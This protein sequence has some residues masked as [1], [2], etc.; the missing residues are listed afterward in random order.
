MNK[1]CL[2]GRLTTKPELRT[3]SNNL[4]T[5]RFTLAV[6]RNFANAQGEREADFITI[7]AWRKQAENICQYL[8]KGSLVSV[9]GRIQTG[10]FDD[11]DGNK[12]Y[13]TEVIADQVNFLESKSQRAQSSNSGQS[14]G[15]SPYDYQ[16]TT[17]TNQVNVDND[18][19]ADFGDSVSIDD[20]FLD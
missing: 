16:N 10:S 19:F 5:T 12:R 6:N 2:I 14:N 9:E 8:D 20:N 18:P 1:V 15:P 11:K 17:P 4:S 7:V 13:T 3:T